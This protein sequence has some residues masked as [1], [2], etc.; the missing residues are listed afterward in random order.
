MAVIRI[1]A[2]QYTVR[3]LPTSA[4]APATVRASRM[5]S[6]RP[7]MTVPTAFPRSCGAASV[8]A[9]G[10][11]IWA[12]TDSSPVS[13]VPTSSTA[14]LVAND[15]IKRPPADSSVISTIRLRRSN[16][17]PSGTS[18]ISPAA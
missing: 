8:A 13:A 14:M 18:R 12:T 15:E 7:L 5:P 16:M 2:T 11:R 9:N 3:Q 6:N 4:S 1:A 17:S 10:T